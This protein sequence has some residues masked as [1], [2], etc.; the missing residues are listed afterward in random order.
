MLAIELVNDEIPPL[1]ITDHASKAL[2]WM[3]EFRVSHLP[4]VNKREFLGL[5]SDTELIDINKPKEALSKLKVPLIKASVTQGQHAFEALKLISGLHL[6]LIAVLDDKNNFLGCL[7]AV[8]LMQKIAS[9]PFVHEPGGI[10][11]LELN[12]NDYSLAQIA[13]I[14]EGNDAKILSSY[15]TSNSDSTKIELTLKVNKDDL[16][17]ILQTFNRYGY[18]V[19]ASFHLGDYDRDMKGRF[20]EFIHYLNI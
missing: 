5:V 16:S 2:A 10:I 1:K 12:I 19:K 17:A 18:N 8:N 6:S 14:V 7:T 4:V 13:Q 9:M 3:E 20:D 15:I 11:L